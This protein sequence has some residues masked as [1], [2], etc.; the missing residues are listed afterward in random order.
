[1]SPLACGK[2]EQDSRQGLI[3]IRKYEEHQQGS[4]GVSGDGTAP[5]TVKAN[6][7]HRNCKIFRQC[8]G[9]RVDRY[10]DGLAYFG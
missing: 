10:T 7:F 3:N 4:I 2:F 8:V 9:N 1:M 5:P 6:D